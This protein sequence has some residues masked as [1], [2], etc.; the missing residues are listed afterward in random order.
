MH[1]SRHKEALRLLSASPSIVRLL[2]H[3]AIESPRTMAFTHLERGEPVGSLDLGELRVGALRL[4]AFVIERVEPGSRVLLVFPQSLDFIVAFLGCLY[5][6]AIAVPAALPRNH[7]AADGLKAVASSAQPALAL[8]SRG[9]LSELR[10]VL[11]DTLADPYDWC[12]LE[13]VSADRNLELEDLPKLDRE[14]LAYLQF[15][16]GSTGA[17]KGVEVTHGNLLHNCALLAEA[18]EP[19]DEARIVSWLPFFHDWGLIG[20]V[21]FPLAMRV[22]CYFLDPMEFLYSPRRWLDAISR[23]RATISGSPNFGYQLCC[24]AIRDSDRKE[25]D[26]ST[27]EVAMVGAEPVR[28]E[29]LERFTAAFSRCGFRREALY[30]TYGLA[31]STLIATGGRPGSSPVYLTADR[32][33]LENRQVVITTEESPRSVTLVG[34]GRALGEQDLRIVDP[35]THE[36]CSAERVGE[37]WISGESVSRGYWQHTDGSGSNAVH[38]ARRSGDANKD[39]L[40]TGDLGFLW[41]G[42]LFLCGRLKD[43]IIKGGRNYF[44]EDIERIVEQAHASLRASCGAAFSVDASGAE[45]LVVAHELS[46]GK[47]PPSA[48]VIRA[49]QKAV[50]SELG[51]SADAIVLLKPGTLPKTTSGKT[52]RQLTRALFLKDELAAVASMKAW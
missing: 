44:A 8:T 19:Q 43:L 9:R 29:T 11:Q 34:C 4:A 16:S 12:A 6:G 50:L 32:V 51:T 48:E 27:W 1:H 37:V 40:R 3:H 18:L 49:I 24:D 35:D 23:F 13:D 22:S 31:E 45:R 21:I 20:C 36:D 38:R 10:E 14:T 47:R 25:L 26:L 17:P 33:A 41:K 15:T 7:R 52:R 42:E 5:A 46:Y 39:Y 2:E 28:K 30:P